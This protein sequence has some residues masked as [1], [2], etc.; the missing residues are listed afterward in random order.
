MTGLSTLKAEEPKK[1]EEYIKTLSAMDHLFGGFRRGSIYLILGGAGQGKTILAMQQ[2]ALAMNFNPW[3]R[4]L[5]MMDENRK[6]FFDHLKQDAQAESFYFSGSFPTSKY[7]QYYEEAERMIDHYNP[8]LVI[9]DRH[10]SWLDLDLVVEENIARR[11]KRVAAHIKLHKL[12]EER[13]LCYVRT[14]PSIRRSAHVNSFSLPSHPGNGIAHYTADAI[15]GV[16]VGSLV[17]TSRLSVIVKP[18]KSM[19]KFPDVIRYCIPLDVIFRD[20]E[21]NRTFVL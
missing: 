20:Y 19:K 9:D 1:P 11:K 7:H 4:V 21:W 6:G 16:E 12:V 15:A 2:A 5:L 8:H 18:L 17:P 3:L 14:L 10:W 13:N